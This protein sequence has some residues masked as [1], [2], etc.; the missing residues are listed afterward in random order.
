MYIF[1]PRNVGV[2]SSLSPV[3]EIFLEGSDARDSSVL[4]A[5]HLF[6]GSPF[7]G[8]FRGSWDKEHGLREHSIQTFYYPHCLSSLR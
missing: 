8:L 4:A 5:V 2:S 6:S 7:D 3:T 1:R